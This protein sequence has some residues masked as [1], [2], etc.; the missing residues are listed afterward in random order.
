MTSDESKDVI[1]EIA[2]VELRAVAGDVG[3]QTRH[4][5]PNKSEYEHEEKSGKAWSFDLRK[6]VTYHRV[7]DRKND[8]YFE[9]VVDEETGVVIKYCEEPLSVHFGHGSAKKNPARDV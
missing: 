1:I 6:F 7:T 3:P 5:S 2:G 8:K 4:R 9:S